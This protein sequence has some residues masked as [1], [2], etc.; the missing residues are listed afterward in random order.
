MWVADNTGL[1]DCVL[2]VALIFPQWAPCHAV[3]ATPLLIAFEL[4][5]CIYLYSTS[6]YSL[7]LGIL[8]DFFR[9]MDSHTVNGEHAINLKIVFLPLLAFEIVILVDNFRYFI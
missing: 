4:L 6:V 8:P 3:V 1:C 5:L 7:F 2:T 9:Y